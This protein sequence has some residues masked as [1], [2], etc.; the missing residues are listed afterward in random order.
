MSDN[1]PPELVSLSVREMVA[2][3]FRHRRKILGA[4]L[5]WPAVA[6]TLLLILPPKYR[7]QSDLVVKT[8][9]EYLAQADG[10]AGL[11]APTST[12]QE[13][14]NSEVSLLTGR[15]VVEAAISAIGL[16][17][18]YPSLIND[19]PWFHTILDEAV[20]KFSKDLTVE[21]IKL[22]N[23]IAV[24]FDASSP[25]KA[26]AILDRLVQI[27]ID[28]HTQVFADGE[29]DSYREAIARDVAEIGQLEQHRTQIK[30]DGGIYDIAAQR[31][32]L[33]AQRVA[34]E[35]HLQDVVNSRAMLQ[36]RVRYLKEE[37]PKL[38]ETVRSTAT[39]RN[40]ATDHARQTMIDLRAMEAAMSARY[41]PGNP[42]LQRVR[43]QIAALEPGVRNGD[44]VNVSSAPN[45]VLQ[46]VRSEIVL[47]EAQVAP[48]TA[49]ESRYTALVASL[50]AE[51]D[52]LERADLELRTTSARIDALTDNLK[53]AQSRYDQA[54]TQEQ[55]DAE[56]QVSVVQ[57]AP[58]IAPDR[59]AK[60]S[61]PL[62]LAAGVLLG[63]FSAGGI[64]VAAVLTGK[65][66]VTE[67]GLERLLGL[68]VLLALPA[69]RDAR[70][71]PVTLDVE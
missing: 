52:R 35:S 37:L 50:G 47:A 48:F 14:I 58:A 1:A 9:R 32:A 13:G 49:E 41:A 55:M 45:P 28:K 51:L 56:R 33:I 68:P 40:E 57:V 5:F 31:S 64:A 17:N 46:Q 67:D 18:I 38:P 29:A 11:T 54:R 30:L 39:D 53:Q 34:A 69:M 16:A 66:V 6:I 63:L 20:H 25:G 71:G 4:L 24:S 12:K 21:P 22:S 59:P 62:F 36:G 43:E 65:T 19:P 27:Y 60:P 10:G 8:G 2:I 7:A 61:K 26:K 42:D 23:V 3:A 44:R 15:P 70:D